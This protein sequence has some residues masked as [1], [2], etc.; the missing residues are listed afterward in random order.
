M[1]RHKGG[2]YSTASGSIGDITWSEARSPARVQ[3]TTRAKSH[4]ADPATPNQISHRT[5]VR[6]V[7]RL[8]GVLPHAT[9]QTSLEFRRH[10]RS[11]RN[12]LYRMIY[13]AASVPVDHVVL[14]DSPT[15]YNLGPC[16]RPRIFVISGWVS[17]QLRLSWAT[18]KFGDHSAAA[19]L[20]QGFVIGQQDIS[21]YIPSNFRILKDATNRA[22]GNLYI[23]GLIPGTR[24]FALCWFA[25]T[26]ADGKLYPSESMSEVGVAKV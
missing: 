18:K 26:A 19:D 23:D 8:A 7:G 2:I 3:N 20:L 10:S 22:A 13:Q 14:T 1:A 6:E 17:G 4:P 12:Q 25:H 5:K 15:Y 9:W 16:W 11:S 21:S 24:Y